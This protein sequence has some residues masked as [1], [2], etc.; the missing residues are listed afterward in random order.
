MEAT[1]G[2]TTKTSGFLA[3]LHRVAELPGQFERELKARPFGAV[4]AVA[5]LSF[6]AGMIFG[7]RTARAMIVAATP[8]IVTRLLDGPLGEDLSRYARSAL[9]S[10][11]GT[12]QAAS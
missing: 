9:R 5:G 3:A 10:R 11:P 12:T 6:L 1:N 4:A 7:S 8:V 2:A